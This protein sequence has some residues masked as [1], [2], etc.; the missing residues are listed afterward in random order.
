MKNVIYYIHWIK[1]LLNFTGVV[2][3][4]EKCLKQSN[5]LSVSVTRENRILDKIFT[6]S[7]ITLVSII[8][9]NFGCALDIRSLKQAIIRPI[10]PVIG[11]A[12]HFL[13]LPLVSTF[14]IKY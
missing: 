13:L 10:G 12:N 1:V 8:F 4:S 5:K 11:L 14:Y 6:G 3:N 2:N 7:V 9:I